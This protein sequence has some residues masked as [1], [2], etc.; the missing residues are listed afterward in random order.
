MSDTAPQFQCPACQSWVP[1]VP[2]TTDC[3]ACKA[4]FPRT[5]GILDLRADRSRDTLLDLDSYD[6]DHGVGQASHQIA[7]TYARLLQGAGVGRAAHV[8]EI[9]AGSGNLTLGLAQEPYFESILST[10]I[11]AGFLKRLIGRLSDT[12]T[13]N[14][15]LAL[16][17]GNTLP[18]HPGGFDAVIGHSILHHIARF[19]D[20]L[21]QCHKLTKPGGACVFGEPILDVHAFASL[22]AQNILLAAEMSGHVFDKKERQVLTAVAGRSA[23]KHGNL[24]GDRDALAQVEDKFQFSIDRMAK[25]G[26]SLGFSEVTCLNPG[27]EMPLGL[28]AKDMLHRVCGQM[29]LEPGFLTPFDGFAEALSTTYGTPLGLSD[30]APFG[31]FVFRK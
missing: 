16:V 8:L 6:A 21:A 2:E 14:V 12:G 29:K 1:V 24:I 22:L 11:S 27:A 3:T 10:D 20:T 19:E 31:F 18:F 17:D 26:R 9:G 4:P 30:R 13:E 28:R 25:L 5:D 15:S 23:I 7:A